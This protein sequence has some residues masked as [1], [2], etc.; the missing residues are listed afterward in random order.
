MSKDWKIS[1]LLDVYG[2]MFL[3]EKQ[4]KVVDL[5]YNADLS[6]SEIA[7]Q[8]AI[9]RQGVRDSIKRGELTLLEAEDKLGFYKKQQETEKLLDTIRKSV[10][11][12]LE[13]NRESI[14]SR[15]VEKQMQ[16][17]L[18]CVDQMDSEE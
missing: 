11:A 2:K 12:V 9:T 7:Q 13:E 10:N 16:R 5:Y 15:S 1:V 14:R 4:Y 6:L 18:T 17:I 8:E 3:T